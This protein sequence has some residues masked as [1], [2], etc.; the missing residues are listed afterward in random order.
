MSATA[1]KKRLP[2]ARSLVKIIIS[3]LVILAIAIAVIF[4]IHYRQT[5]NQHID[6]SQSLVIISKPGN[7]AQF[8]AGDSIQVEVDATGQQPFTSTEL[9]INGVLEGVQASPPSGLTSLTTFYSWIPSE[10]G[11]FSLIARAI[12]QENS[13]AISSAVIVF[14][15][16]PDYGD[17]PDPEAGKV[18]PV[19]LPA[20]PAGHTSPPTPGPGDVPTPADEWQGSPGDWLNSL[21]TN[22]APEAPE[23]AVTAEGCNV[24]LD[25]HDL[26]ENEE[27]F[28]VF[29]QTTNS[30]EWVHVAD[31]ASH[32]GKGWIEYQDINLSGGVTYYISAFNS[33]GESSSNL[34]LVNIDPE[35]CP[36]P[37]P[38]NKLP[39]LYLKVK[40]L[41]IA[42]NNGGIYCYSSLVSGQWSRW[43]ERGFIMADGSGQEVPPLVK[44]LVLA[45]L[46][47]A[48]IHPGPQSLDLKLECWGWQGGKL[49]SLGGLKETID[50]VNPKDLHA[51]FS[52]A[53]FEINP[54]ILM[55]L[56]REL[57]KLES[58]MQPWIETYK[59]PYAIE[60]LGYVPESDQMPPIQAAITDSEQI[61]KSLIQG[62]FE[63][64]VNCFPM[65]GYNAGPGG[66]NP[67][68]YLIWTV[69]DGYCA[70]YGE[71][72]QCF[73]LIWWENFA[74]KYPDPHYPG[75]QWML[76]YDSIG[77]PIDIGQQ[78]SRILPDFPPSGEG[79]CV[80]GYQHVQV[81]LDINTSLGEILSSP[82]NLVTVPCPQPLGDTV[83]IEV[84]FYSLTLDN[85]DD[86][87]GDDVADAIHGWFGITPGGKPDAIRMGPMGKD[88]IDCFTPWGQMPTFGLA[89]SCTDKGIGAFL[90]ENEYLCPYEPYGDPNYSYGCM[91]ESE[92][93]QGK[94]KIVVTLRDQDAL[95]IYID[96]LEYDNMSDNDTIC[97]TGGWVG[98]RTLKQ[99]AGTF[100]EALWYYM[101]DNGDASCALE[102]V[103]NALSPN[104]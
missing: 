66:A 42:E 100:N 54:N 45:T 68:L 92:Y 40:N 89:G 101:D 9:W 4:I 29:R 52:G 1:G 28:A 94:N 39:V 67:Q 48:G 36:P 22:S 24:K 38:P 77:W 70:G 7:M 26:S 43:P 73:P 41:S 23:L 95:Q 32:A 47:E 88:V 14:I 64:E 10:G 102:V 50:L 72:N 60:T 53:T 30:Q 2:L 25:I 46:D 31:L 13:T 82:S 65:P 21:T 55:G 74:R 84:N 63:Q 51:A 97:Q 96:L 5:G 16:P 104:P 93:Q 20:P 35:A 83:D 15:S 79:L 6:T 33:K 17:Q 58:G 56:E 81:Y 76:D 91:V 69:L 78:A 44:P 37:E 19:V 90:L 80:D 99:W 87:S 34:A 57:F 27:G 62:P 59:D 49:V 18:N 11:N 75:A 61:C 71:G 3:I 98:P 12:N 103:L 85:I 8:P 86:G